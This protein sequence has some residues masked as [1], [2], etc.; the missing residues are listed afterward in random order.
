M[1]K[2]RLGVVVVAIALLIVINP[3]LRALLLLADAMSVEVLFFF[4]A[5]QVRSFGPAV[6]QVVSTLAPVVRR[7]IW[8]CLC[9]WLRALSGALLMG[10][11]TYALAVVLSVFAESRNKAG[12]LRHAVL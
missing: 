6:A 5:M 12:S 10:P 4:F 8:G 2:S 9:W 3:E 7:A 1:S 11:F